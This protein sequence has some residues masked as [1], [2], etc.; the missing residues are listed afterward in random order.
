MN[1]KTRNM[2]TASVI[3]IFIVIT[4]IY[5]YIEPKNAD[6]CILN[7]IKDAKSDTAAQLIARSCHNL[8]LKE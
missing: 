2:I 4:A 1:Q 6:E 7:N 5:T 3:I 8:Y